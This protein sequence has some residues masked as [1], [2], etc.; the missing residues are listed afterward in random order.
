MPIMEFIVHYFAHALTIHIFSL[1]ALFE[2]ST[3]RN[4][5]N[6][7]ESMENMS[8]IIIHYM[9]F[10]RYRMLKSWIWSKCSWQCA[11]SQHIS[12][13]L[14]LCTHK[15]ICLQMVFVHSFVCLSGWRLAFHLILLAAWSIYVPHH[16]KNEHNGYAILFIH[17]LV[18]LL[19]LFHF[20]ATFFSWL[21]AY[22]C[23]FTL[24]WNRL[25]HVEVH[26]CLIQIVRSFHSVQSR[27]YIYRCNAP[28]KQ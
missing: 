15:W 22:F 19:L 17:F 5:H 20:K 21:F 1:C 10:E 26:W 9:A 8:T 23:L 6:G 27:M 7:W 2:S 12:S 25:I 18:P 16:S 11:I 4:R 13:V 14:L 28:N 24:Q 3:E